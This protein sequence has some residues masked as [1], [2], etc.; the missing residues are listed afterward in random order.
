MT[1]GKALLVDTLGFRE[2]DQ[3]TVKGDVGAESD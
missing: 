3:F 1:L 2:G